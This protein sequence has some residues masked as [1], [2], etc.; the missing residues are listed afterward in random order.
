MRVFLQ[1]ALVDPVLWTLLVKGE[2]ESTH[3]LRMPKPK[4]RVGTGLARLGKILGKMKRETKERTPT[5]DV[6]SQ[7][8]HVSPPAHLEKV[9]SP[10]HQ[11]AAAQ[12]IMRMSQHEYH[13]TGELSH[14]LRAQR[15]Q[16][17][18][19][20]FAAQGIVPTAQHHADWADHYNEHSSKYKGSKVPATSRARWHKIA[21]GI[22]F[23]GYEH[24]QKPDWTEAQLRAAVAPKPEPS[25]ASDLPFSR[26][27]QVFPPE[28]KE[29]IG[30]TRKII[31]YQKSLFN[32]LLMKACNL[33]LWKAKTPEDHVQHGYAR[34]HD[35]IRE[36]IQ[37]GGDHKAATRARI[38]ATSDPHKLVGIYHAAKDY[39]MHSIATEANTKLKKL[40]G[41]TVRSYPRPPEPIKPHTGVKGE[42][43][44]YPKKPKRGESAEDYHKRVFT[45]FRIM[46]KPHAQAH[47]IAFKLR[48]KHYGE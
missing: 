7:P 5:A 12:A 16:K 26:P 2:E 24:E 29:T 35:R 32:L 14:A 39:K 43:P 6:P 30:Y 18:L 37:Y 40:H 21:G 19:N 28:V 41:H 44:K 22:E 25:P 11:A 38:E 48:E 3:A 8:F 31:P 23:S 33:D 45:H 15:A 13:R 1:S 10:H 20:Q 34:A 42:A 27:P 46:G 47:A 4:G 9:S 36:T 17:H